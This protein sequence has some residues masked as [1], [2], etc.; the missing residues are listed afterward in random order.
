MTEYKNFDE[1][2]ACLTVAEIAQIMR[3]SAPTAYALAHTGSFPAVKVGEKRYIVPKDK[4]L[5]WL[6]RGGD[7]AKEA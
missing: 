1:M 5:A 4:F 7:A 2:P 3:V 6:Y